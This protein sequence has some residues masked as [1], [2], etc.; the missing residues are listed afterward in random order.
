MKMLTEEKLRELLRSMYNR[1][2]TE[3]SHLMRDMRY[4]MSNS[5]I[6]DRTRKEVHQAGDDIERIIAGL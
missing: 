4:R 3:G 1:G 2:R 6:A 5:E